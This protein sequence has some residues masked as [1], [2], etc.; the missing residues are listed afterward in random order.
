[1]ILAIESL[2]PCKGWIFRNCI[3]HSDFFDLRLDN[4]YYLGVDWN[5][6]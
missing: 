5:V 6:L 2:A 1:M 3:R 4:I